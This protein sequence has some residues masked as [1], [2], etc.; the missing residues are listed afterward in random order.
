M[1]GGHIVEVGTHE[2]LIANDGLYA[3]LWQRQSGGFLGGIDQSE[4]AQ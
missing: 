2:A 4:A 1:D 3:S